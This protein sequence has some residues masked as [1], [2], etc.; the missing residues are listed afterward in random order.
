ML[1]QN[2]HICKYTISINMHKIS[3]KVQN[4]KCIN[5][6]NQICKNMQFQNMHKYVIY[7]H[8]FAL[9]ARI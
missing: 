2:M 6:Q 1:N 7:M 9:Y 4:Q 8:K 5:M 3:I